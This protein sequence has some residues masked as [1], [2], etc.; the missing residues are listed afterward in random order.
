[1]HID[2]F[3][4]YLLGKQHPYYLR[5]PSLQAPFPETGRDGVPLEE[6]LALRALDPKFR[7]KRGRRKAEDVDDD[8]DRAS[9]PDPKRPHLDTSIEFGSPHAFAHPQSAYPQS[10]IPMSGRSDDMDRFVNAHDPWTT[11]TVPHAVSQAIMGP[12]LGK[13]LTPSSTMTPSAS[14]QLNWRLHGQDNTPATPHPMSAITPMT[15]QIP[16]SGF[17]EPRSAITPFSSKPRSRRR[18]GPAVS[19]A[20]SSGGGGT[21]GGKLRGRPPANRSVRDG[22]FVTFPANPKGRERPGVDLYRSTPAST[23]VADRPPSESM[24]ANRHFQFPP[25]PPQRSDTTPTTQIR[26]ERLQLRVPQHVGGPVH[27]VTPTVLVNGQADAGGPNI[28]SQTDLVPAR[29]SGYFFD[30]CGGGGGGGGGGTDE[31]AEHE[32]DQSFNA[33]QSSAHRSERDQHAQQPYGPTL[34]F[35]LGDLK[36]ALTADLLR[37]TVVGRKRLRGFEAKHLADAM[38]KRLRSRPEPSDGAAETVFRINCASWLGLSHAV[39]TSGGSVGSGKRILVQRYRVEEDGYEVPVEEED[40]PLEAG[41]EGAKETCDVS[42]SLLPR[43][44]VG[45]F[46]DQGHRFAAGWAAGGWRR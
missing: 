19:S 37:A 15:A 46:P 9:T 7:P 38:I 39:G 26:P 1:M 27:L 32:P 5:I 3:F 28:S 30:E 10:A 11:P 29:M 33:T 34:A 14:Q 13:L 41:G 6:D 4:E 36:R 18:H 40:E 45:G 25:D 44:A 35:E 31:P 43:W 22:P 20:W 23:P 24:E 12:S 42:W 2:A 16:D 21:A 8:Q 17:D